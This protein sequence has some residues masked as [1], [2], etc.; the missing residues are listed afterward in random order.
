MALSADGTTQTAG[1]EIRLASRPVGEPEL[2]NFELADIDIPTIGDEQVL[3]RNTWMSVDPY[4]RG[5]MNDVESYLPPFQ[6]DAPL[7]GG[8]VGEV[9]ASRSDAV[10]AGAT[11]SHFLGWR[12]FAVV[13]AADATVLDTTIAPAEAYLGALGLTGLTAYAAVTEVTPVRSGD[14]VFVSAAAGAVGSIAGQLARTFG[15]SRVIGSAG[16]P[17]KTTKLVEQFGFDAAIDYRA[18]S[19]EKQLA[20][21]APDGI[22]LYVDNVGGDHLEAAIGAM[23][24]GGRIA[25]VGS[26]SG[27]NATGPVPGPRDFF[28]AQFKSL[29]LRGM[30]VT[31]Y[32]HLLPEY[33]AMAAPWLVDGSLRTET[34]VYTGLDQAP[35]ALLGVLNGSNVGKMLVRLGD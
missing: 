10:P 19:I 14:V 27:Y 20:E 25:M 34:T 8:A 6:L 4:M 1:R 30:I 28:R 35:A 15:A 16:G 26:I 11:V 5:R 18:G 17:A 29:T 21:L 12:D 13:D 32:L 7:E 2:A 9:V 24:A 33:V 22:D 3:V 31:D 23:R